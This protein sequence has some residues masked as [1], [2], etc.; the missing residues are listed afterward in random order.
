MGFKKVLYQSLHRKVENYLMQRYIDSFSLG[1]R[2]GKS[3]ESY[4]KLLRLL[5]SKY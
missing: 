1:S 3:I 4:R 5:M 2:Y